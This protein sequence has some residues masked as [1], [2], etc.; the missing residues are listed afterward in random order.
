M[1]KYNFVICPVCGKNFIP[2]VKHIYKIKIMP[3][4]KIRKVC[5]YTCQNNYEKA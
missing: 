4:Y 2:A 3:G 1:N 5:S